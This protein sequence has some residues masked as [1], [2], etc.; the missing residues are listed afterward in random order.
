M[1]SR[2]Y[3]AVA[4][5]TVVAFVLISGVVLLVKSSGGLADFRSAYQLVVVDTWVEA[6][7]AIVAAA[8]AYIFGNLAAT[9][10]DNRSRLNSSK[11]VAEI[12]EL[13]L[14]KL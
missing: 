11:S 9:V 6:F 3:V 4:L 14:G 12:N 1:S 7:N 2:V 13:K 8:V 10:A 5:G